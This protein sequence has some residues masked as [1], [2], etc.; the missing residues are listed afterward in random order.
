MK[1]LENIVRW[2]VWAKFLA[3]ALTLY[4]G[5][6]CVVSLSVFISALRHGQHL[7][8][9]DF[10]IQTLMTIYLPLLCLGF[11]RP[12]LSSGLLFTVAAVDLLL[13]FSSSTSGDSTG[14][15]L[16]GSTLFLGI[17]LLGSALLFHYISRAPARPRLL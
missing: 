7:H 12:R 1:P 4:A 11:W 6:L 15:M 9:A 10:V 14:A 3:G 16:A 2:P 5:L 13:L 8:G 17:P